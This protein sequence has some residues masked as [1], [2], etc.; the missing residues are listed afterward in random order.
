[1][2]STLG[3]MIG[4]YHI[5]INPGHYVRVIMWSLWGATFLLGCLS[6]IVVYI[7]LVSGH[8]KPAAR[9][10]IRKS[11]S[12]PVKILRYLIPGVFFVNN[13]YSKTVN[14]DRSLSRRDAVILV[15]VWSTWGVL[16]AVLGGFYAHEAIYMVLFGAVF[17]V[18]GFFGW[19]RFQGILK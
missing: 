2:G 19:A 17:L 11:V 8:E 4:L 15:G 14:V 13:P 5:Y 1:M 6:S 9:E 18:P 10:V 16:D 12:L 3:L 7:K